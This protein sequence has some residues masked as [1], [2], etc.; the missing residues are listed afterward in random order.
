[1]D[2]FAEEIIKRRFGPR[3]F[4]LTFLVL[5][6]AAVIT[7]AALYLLPIIL[8]SLMVSFL[9]VAAAWYGAYY[10]ITALSVE[11]EY[12]VT[13]SDVTIDTIIYHRKRKRVVSLDAKNVDE[14]GKVTPELR[15]KRFQ[16]E[17][18]AGDMH[19][20]LETWYMVFNHKNF[21]HTVLYFTP[22]EKVLN[23]IKPF[24]K[25]QVS[26]NAFDRH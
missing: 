17:I 4:G 8:P 13:N 24:L 12:S 20:E 6:G 23:A 26:L 16:K 21:G 18:F 7:F 15:N 14:M 22:S 1:M 9:I 2:T 19:G 25:R 5:T 10:L 11:F 3:E